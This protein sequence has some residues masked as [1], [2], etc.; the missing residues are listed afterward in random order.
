[1]V[2]TK[3]SEVR[4][5][6]STVS[7]GVGVDVWGVTCQVGPVR[8][9]EW[10]A[11]VS[12]SPSAGVG[13]PTRVRRSFPPTRH[14]L[15]TVDIHHGPGCTTMTTSDSP[16]PSPFNTLL[17]H[18]L[19]R[20]S[21]W[22]SLHL[23]FRRSP[24][25]RPS[26]HC[27]PHLSSSLPAMSTPPPSSHHCPRRPAAP[28]PHT[29][30]SAGRLCSDQGRGSH[31]ALGP[32]GDLSGVC[33]PTN[34]VQKSRTTGKEDGPGR[35][36]FQYEMKAH[37]GSG[38][39]QT[40]VTR[41][42]QWFQQPTQKGLTTPAWLNAL[43]GSDVDFHTLSADEQLLLFVLDK[44]AHPRVSFSGAHRGVWDEWVEGG[45]R[46]ELE[47]RALRREGGAHLEG[48]RRAGLRRSRLGRPQPS[49]PRTR[50]SSVGR[51]QARICHVHPSRAASDTCS[52]DHG[53]HTIAIH[54]S[55]CTLP[56]ETG[57][58][59]RCVCLRPP[60][61]SPPPSLSCASPPSLL[62]LLLHE[63]DVLRTARWGGNG[64]GQRKGWW[65]E[66]LGRG[67]RAGGLRGCGRGGGGKTAVERGRGRGARQPQ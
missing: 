1:M 36:Y 42:L 14:D 43:K 30:P 59:T 51:R 4:L 23:A 15:G 53:S 55:Y 27:S 45:V 32:R 34:S 3:D 19:R 52:N 46:E 12:V 54:H 8:R 63:V 9:V 20:P 62:F 50:L 40:A 66:G 47:G 5:V 6:E 25:V 10:S 57:E 49:S 61:S 21:S 2:E 29:L 64:S 37:G 35:G 16:L 44:N 67:R 13:W 33:H 31:P 65:T 38:T 11:A 17:S 26:L 28:H 18:I 24:L 56:R 39:N 7:G 58:P 48:Q 60:S 22:P 41:A